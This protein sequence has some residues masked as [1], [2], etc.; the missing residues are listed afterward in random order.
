[1]FE[2]E[3]SKYSYTMDNYNENRYDNITLLK[4]ILI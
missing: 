1:M 4:R 2:D 3:S